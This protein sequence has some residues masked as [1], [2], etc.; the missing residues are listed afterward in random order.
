VPG[1]GGVVGTTT[2]KKGGASRVTV[3]EAKLVAAGAVGGGGFW[4]A[5]LTRKTLRVGQKY[6]QK[7]VAPTGTFSRPNWAK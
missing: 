7:I 4:L 5:G 1:K 3:G 6:P 2:L